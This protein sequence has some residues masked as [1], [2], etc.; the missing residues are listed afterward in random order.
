MG[1]KKMVII[2]KHVELKV[3]AKPDPLELVNALYECFKLKG[4]VVFKGSKVS[5]VNNIIISVDGFA[6]IELCSDDW[7]TGFTLV[8]KKQ[9]FFIKR[10]RLKA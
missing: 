8:M 10:K 1:D 5:Y 2:N 9:K 7:G 4:T 3:P 6:S